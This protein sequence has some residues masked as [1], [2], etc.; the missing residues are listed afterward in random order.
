MSVFCLSQQVSKAE[1]DEVLRTS[2]RSATL[3]VAASN[4][5]IDHA[6]PDLTPEQRNL[7]RQNTGRTSVELPVGFNIGRVRNRKKESC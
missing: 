7:L 1:A 2:R 6:I 4:R 3:D 5:F